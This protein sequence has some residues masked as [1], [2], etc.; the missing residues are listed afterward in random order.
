MIQKKQITGQGKHGIVK[1]AE[2]NNTLAESLKVVL[3]DTFAF[4]L[5]AHNYHWNVEG[6]N[7]ND[8]HAFFATL[9]NEA[10]LATDLIAEHIRTLDEY[11]PASFGRFYQLATISDEV[12]IPTAINMARK[13][14]EDNKKVIVSLTSAHKLSEKTNKIGITNFLEDRIDIHEKHGWMLRAITKGRG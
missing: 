2:Q 1:M 9:Y 10:W 12:N 13:L 6:E 8:Y 4:Y 7:F 3:A 14:E 5:K 11:V